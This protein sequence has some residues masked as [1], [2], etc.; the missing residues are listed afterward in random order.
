M[1]LNLT[2]AI[3]AAGLCLTVAGLS[4]AITGQWRVQLIRGST[5]VTQGVGATEAAAWAD[6]VS[7][8]P[9]T[10]TAPTVYACQTMR[11]YATVTPDPVPPPPPAGTASLSWKAPISNDD[12]SAFTNLAGY[13]LH[14]GASADALTQTIQIPGPNVSYTVTGLPPGTYFFAVRAYT[15]GGVQSDPSNVVSKIVL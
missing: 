9:K 12:G 8:I 1:R 5:T 7:K 10:A 2:A 13:R 11:Y 14:Y 4:A 6:C 15:S 3:A